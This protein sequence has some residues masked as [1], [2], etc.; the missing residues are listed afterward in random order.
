VSSRSTN[1]DIHRI[2]AHQKYASFLS[3]K[4]G[5]Q[6]YIDIWPFNPAMY[7]NSKPAAW[8]HERGKPNGPLVINF[9]WRNQADDLFWMGNV[10]AITDTLRKESFEQDVATPKTPI[11]YN[12]A[13]DGTPVED[14]YQEHTAELALIRTKYD[15]GNVM[16]RTGGFRV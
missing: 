11:Y 4:D 13:L 7:D 9:K 6:I 3:T 10:R 1:Q 8:P 15:P 2:F 14:I 5:L 16:N 12:L